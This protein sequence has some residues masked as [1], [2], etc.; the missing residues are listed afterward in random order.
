MAEAFDFTRDILKDAGGIDLEYRRMSRSSDQSFWGHGVPSTL[1]ALSEQEVDDSPTGRAHAALLGGGGRAGGLGWWW[2]TTEDTID[3][4]DPDFL[5]RDAWL[6]LAVLWELCTRNRLPFKPQ[7]G[8]LEL[9]DG[10]ERAQ[11]DAKGGLDLD[12]L[13]VQA[14]AL[15]DRIDA[16]DLAAMP[17]ERANALVM[18]LCR[19]I[20]PANYTASGPFEHDL[21]LG[22]SPAMGLADTAKLGNL[23]PQSSDYRFL[24]TRLVRAR[25]RVSGA[26][27]DVERQLNTLQ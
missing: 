23:D 21:A 19:I 13:T 6:Y 8:L 16:I 14:R 10:M 4:I 2:H 5:V 27:R 25:N 20:I 22:G 12:D 15:A 26:L 9:A 3:K 18:D 17:V 1:A 7:A 24:R 11:A